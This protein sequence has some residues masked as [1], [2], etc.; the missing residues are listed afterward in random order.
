MPHIT[1]RLVQ[2][3]LLELLHHHCTLHLKTLLTECQFQHTV[4]LQPEAD[5]HIRFWNRQVVIGNI[6]IG[7]CIIL[8][9][10]QLQ[11]SVIIRNMHR[12]SKHQMLKQMGKA[13][14]L[15]MLV[16]GTYVINNIQGN[17]LRAGIF[18]VH[19]PQTVVKYLFVYLH[20]ME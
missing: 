19:Q 3:T 5:F 7:P 12:T 8:P 13:R 2:T 1:I 16:T 10:C 4:G 20:K 18:I 17:H 14:M 6:I 15:G 9:T 11:R